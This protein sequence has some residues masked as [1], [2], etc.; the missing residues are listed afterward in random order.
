M[1][2]HYSIPARS[3]FQKALFLNVACFLAA[4]NDRFL[5]T[6]SRGRSWSVVR[7]HDYH[8]LLLMD[9]IVFLHCW[10][11]IRKAVLFLTHDAV[12]ARCMLWH[13]VCFSVCLS[14]RLS[15]VGVL[16]KQLSISLRKPRHAIAYGLQFSDANILLKFTMGSPQQGCQ[17]QVR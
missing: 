17:M 14:V 9:I 11:G 1:V 6:D 3:C 15:Q 10:F 13:C 16:S 2:H 7:L 8:R 12:L 5:V 4:G